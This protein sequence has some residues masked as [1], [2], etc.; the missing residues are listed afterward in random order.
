MQTKDN[1][2][3]K[4]LTT[5]AILGTLAVYSSH[6][7][8]A[9]PVNSFDGVINGPIGAGGVFDTDAISSIRITGLGSYTNVAGSGVSATGSNPFILCIEDG[10]SVTGSTIGVTNS[11]DFA[12]I[13]NGGT[14]TGQS[15]RGVNMSAWG[16]LNNE[17]TGSITGATSAAFLSGVE[18]S[19]INAGTINGGQHGVYLFNGSKMENLETG[20][21]FGTDYGVYGANAAAEVVND[22]DITSA[23]GTGIGLENGG[24][25]SNNSTGNIIGAD[26]G[27]VIANASGEV[28]NA[29]AITAFSGDGI[30]LEAGGTVNNLSGGVI[31]GANNGVLI[32]T[33]LGEITNEGTIDG[34]DF[35][36]LLA[37]GGSIDNKDGGIITGV[38]DAAAITG[39]KGTITNAGSITSSGGFGAALYA[40]G[41]IDN[42]ATGQI[43]GD[44]IGAR[45]IGGNAEINN[46]GSISGVTQ[47]G[48][49][50][51]NGGS[52]TN[53]SGAS[54]TGE[55]FGVEIE[56]AAGSVVNDGTIASNT[57]SAVLLHEGGSVENLENRNIQGSDKGVHFMSETG[58]LVNHGLITGF[59]QG[60]VLENG[61]S[62]ENTAT[63][64][65]IGGDIG[66]QMSGDADFENS[67]EIFGNTTFGLYNLGSGDL[68]NNSGG[69]ISGADSGLGSTGDGAI[70]NRAGGEIKG[71]TAGVVT[72]NA[73]A[74]VLNAGVIT[75]DADIGISMQDGGSVTNE[76]GGAISG[77]NIGVLSAG[78][79]VINQSGAE[80]SGDEYG[81]AMGGT[82]GSV[83]NAG[84]I[85]AL[86]QASVR[87]TSGG[88]VINREGGE[89]SGFVYIEGDTGSV[90]NQGSIKGTLRG[91]MLFDGGTVNNEAGGTI[92]GDNF[93]VRGINAPMTVNNAGT[94]S[95]INNDG[96]ST[97]SD[98]TFNN[99]V[100]GIINGNNAAIS[101]FGAG[102]VNNQG[103]INGDVNFWTE[104]DT[105]HL[106]AGSTLNGDVDGNDGIDSLIVTGDH[107]LG[108]IENFENATI[109]DGFVEWEDET[110]SLNNL[111]VQGGHLS[112]AGGADNVTVGA[113]GMLSGTGKFGDIALNGTIAPG[114]SAGVL[115]VTGDLTMSETAKYEAEIYANNTNDL[116]DVTGAANLNGALEIDMVDAAEDYEEGGTYTILTADGGITGTFTT[117]TAKGATTTSYAL[118]EIDGNDVKV[119]IINPT[120]YFANSGASNNEKAASV[121]LAGLAI[122]SPEAQSLFYA[123]DA[124]VNDA[125]EEL[126]GNSHATIAGV[127][128]QD[129]NEYMTAVLSE[130]RETEIE[131]FSSWAKLFGTSGTAS[132]DGNARSYEH[133]QLGVAVGVG[134]AVTPEITVGLQGGH[135]WS[136]ATFTSDVAKV[137]TK[138]FGAYVASEYEQFNVAAVY[139]HGWNNVEMSRVISLAGTAVNNTDTKSNKFQLEA[140][141]QF[142]IDNL[143]IAPVVGYNR[144]VVKSMALNESGAG[145][146]NLNGRTGEFVSS[147]PRAGLRVSADI[148]VKGNS[149]IKPSVGVM[150]VSEQ[151]DLNG[152]LIAA[153]QGVPG[154]N[155]TVSGLTM[156][157][158]RFEV[159]AGVS[160]ETKQN[161]TFSIGYRGTYMSR[162]KS[163]GGRASIKFRF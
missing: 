9:C 142:K 154:N 12:Y 107:K 135:T 132:S 68:I 155:F 105:L 4:L 48:V 133:D 78:G 52:V 88:E 64:T 156:D 144:T 85:S 130:A 118:S 159:D 39:G 16:T 113:E 49:Y 74:N 87:L 10:G 124:T 62:V 152:G 56:G 120:E 160:Y 18:S 143:M 28:K 25:V 14:I 76:T 94:I 75:G 59:D 106:M 84:K 53:E 27:I 111:T 138:E 146:A 7:E 41:A 37:A 65:I 26:D 104:N 83:D 71:S 103:T 114:N 23:G 93:G 1:R 31:D 70:I 67:G 58:E 136:D 98:A 90:T 51:N 17:E 95:G 33:N 61:G 139:S 122:S 13:N 6:A 157:K 38:N 29:G 19:L 112:F 43:Q 79:S 50:F 60:V 134:Y 110:V 20:A 35:G 149:V 102:V 147:Q 5:T 126:S 100:G 145:A 131:G 137:K 2:Y 91:I 42:K 32:A 57:N 80:I 44:T 73:N 153:A 115:N 127:V 34:S 77:L 11:T 82:T 89:L 47:Q 121:A 123:D 117:T 81:V 72:A 3:K 151:G 162:I 66:V 128:A 99:Q 116:I 158:N 40:G 22:G 55:T 46:A 129:G 141:Y 45:I 8:A 108:T 140:S 96:F 30:R 15:G 63:A 54:I 119:N 148:P 161:I 101:I 92:T 69:L 97:N 36:A 150:F 21:I 163:H 125:L 86:N 109:N 24:K